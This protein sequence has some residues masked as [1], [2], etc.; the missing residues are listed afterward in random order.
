MVSNHDPSLQ[1][2]KAIFWVLQRGHKI[3]CNIKKLFRKHYKKRWWDQ[4]LATPT[5]TVDG[6]KLF[7]I[8][9]M[10][11]SQAYIMN[12]CTEWTP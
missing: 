7:G 4:N 11:Y 10:L 12:R 2:T 1:S 9:G 8:L 5:V 6:K 3:A